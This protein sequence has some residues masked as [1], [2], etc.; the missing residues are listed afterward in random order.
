M[1]EVARVGRHTVFALALMAVACDS[2]TEVKLEERLGTIAHT[3]EGDPKINVSVDNRD[4]RITIKTSG[5][6]CVTRGPTESIIHETEI[7]IM[8]FDTV[9]HEGVCTDI[10]RE[11]DHV[12]LIL[13]PNPGTYT[14]IIHGTEG[15]SSDMIT[16]FREI[17]VPKEATG[18]RAQNTLL[19]NAEP[20]LSNEQQTRLSHIQDRKYAAEVHT[21]QLANDPGS[22]LDDEREIGID[23]SPTE[24]YAVIIERRTMHESGSVSWHGRPKKGNGE[25]RITLNDNAAYGEL[26]VGKNQFMIEALGNGLHAIIRVDPTGFGV[27]GEPISGG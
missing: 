4:I 11:F 25:F 3:D 7:D 6:G 5:N 23:V 17:T 15:S 1:E 2:P 9:R 19:R 27:E 26:M 13:V 18:A 16:I 12:A 14:A 8:P 10:Y 20:A 21:A 22:M 24:H